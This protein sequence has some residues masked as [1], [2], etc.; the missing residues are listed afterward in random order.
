MP[1][2]SDIDVQVSESTISFLAKYYNMT[3]YH[4]ALPG[5]P[6]GRT[7]LLEINPNY[8]IRDQADYLNVI[9]ARWIDTENGLFIDIST[10]RPD[11]IKRSEGVRGALMCKDKHAYLEQDIF[12]L[13]DSVFEG[14]RVKIP[15]EYSKL[16]VE[17]YG[18]QSLTNT[19]FLGYHFDEEKK[20][21]EQSSK[22]AAGRSNG[23]KRMT[24]KVGG[25]RAKRSYKIP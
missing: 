11:T 1:W 9:D 21:W 20:A 12:P 25:L 22:R 14:I 7:Y 15:F 13:R 17:E 16:L 19:D 6:N 4:Y 18:E 8:I 10:V 3:E 23:S 5:V 2:D 24:D